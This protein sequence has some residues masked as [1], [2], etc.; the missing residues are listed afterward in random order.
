VW[1]FRGIILLAGAVA[2][3]WLGT[4]NAGTKVDFRF[5][6]WTFYNL[7][8]NVII[9]VTF[10]AGMLVWAIGG[11]IREAQLLLRVNREKKNAKRLQDEVA[12]LRNLPLEEESDENLPEEMP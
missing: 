4:L 1:I 6:N 8:V 11:W 12:A 7:Q 9:V 10:I 3:I 5:F 2:L